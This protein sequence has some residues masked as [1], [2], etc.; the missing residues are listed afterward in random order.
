MTPGRIVAA[1]QPSLLAR[2]ASAGMSVVDY[3]RAAETLIFM[4]EEADHFIPGRRE[5]AADDDTT[6]TT[7]EPKPITKTRIERTK[8]LVRRS[9][10]SI[11][12]VNARPRSI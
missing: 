1:F 7:D 6:S 4:V 11:D 5:T 9:P 8:S 10:S 3:V 2:E 12:K